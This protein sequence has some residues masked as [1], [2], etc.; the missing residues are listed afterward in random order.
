VASIYHAFGLAP[1]T[2]MHD[3]LGRPLAISEGRV[4]RQLF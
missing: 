4:I 3:P 2:L 1:E